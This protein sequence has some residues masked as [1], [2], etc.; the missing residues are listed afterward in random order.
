MIYKVFHEKMHM[1][2]EWSKFNFDHI[3]ILRGMN[4]IY[5]YIWLVFSNEK[6]WGELTISL[7]M[8]IY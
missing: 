4:M 8:S 1:L 3:L 5:E 6:L 2:E 7:Q